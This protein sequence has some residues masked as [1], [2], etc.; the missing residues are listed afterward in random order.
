MSKIGCATLI[1]PRVSF[2]F[3]VFSYTVLNELQLH[4][5][6]PGGGLRRG[7]VQFP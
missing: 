6:M 4:L 1:Q 2:V 7:G 3:P 5:R